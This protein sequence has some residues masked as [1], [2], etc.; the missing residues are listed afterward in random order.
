MR[1]QWRPL[2]P[3]ILTL[4][5]LLC[6][7][8]PLPRT[9]VS[10]RGGLP[11]GAPGLDQSP[12]PSSS[13]GVPRSKLVGTRP[14]L[15]FEPNRGQFDPQVRFASRG[16]GY[17]LFLTDEEAVLSVRGP[18]GSID[19]ATNTVIRLTLDGAN[20]RPPT[21]RDLLPGFVNYLIGN[22]PS[23]WRTEIPTYSRVQYDGVYDGVDLVYYG[24]EGVLEYDLVVEPGTDP[25]QIAMHIGGA[26]RIDLD[27]TGNLL[28]ATKAGTLTMRA[29]VVYQDLDGRREIVEARYAWDGSRTTRFELGAYEPSEPLVID[30]Q[31][32]YSTFL[33]G[34]GDGF[35][36]ASGVAVDAAGSPYIVGTTAT[37]NFP[38]HNPLQPSSAAGGAVVTKLTPDGSQIIYSTYIAGSGSD[39]GIDIAVL[40]NGVAFVLGSTTSTDLPVPN[41]FQAQFGGTSDAFIVQLNAAG[42]AIERGTYLGGSS[43]DSPGGVKFGSGVLEGRLFVHGTTS[44]SNFPTL[45]PGQPTFGG[46]RDAFVT[47]FNPQTLQPVFSSYAGDARDEQA[48]ELIL[49]PIQGDLYIPLVI[50]TS[51]S[52]SA[53]EA[54]RAG[55]I[56]RAVFFNDPE[57]IKLQ[58]DSI[59]PDKWNPI[60]HHDIAWYNNTFGDPVWGPT[61]GGLSSGQGSQA[62][63]S[64]R[65]R[66]G[67][68]LAIA[69]A[70]TPD[71]LQTAV[72]AMAVTGCLP[73][74]PQTTC[75]ER[76]ALFLWDQ[77][78]NIIGHMN[79]GGERR[80]RSFTFSRMTVDLE[81]RFHFIGA[82]SDNALPVVNPIQATY[83][84]SSEGFILTLDPVTGETIFYSY[85]GGSSFEVLADI[86]VDGGGNAWVVGSTQSANFPSTPNAV[87]PALNGRTDA[88]ATKINITPPT[89]ID[90]D[91]LPTSWETRFGL[92]PNSA[93]PANGA[94]GDPDGDG[95]TNAQ[96]LANGTHP[97]G[98]FT[99]YLAEGA[100]GDF[101]D[102]SVALVNPN[103]IS[104]L[105]LLRFLRT[106]GSPVSHY[107]PI[108]SN[109]RA[110]INP[111]SLA[112][113][114]ATAFSTVVESDQ[115]I[116]VDRTMT[117]DAG[118]YGS[119]A[120]TSL[121]APS[122]TW[123]LAEGATHSGFN[124]FY[125]IQ[126]PG[127][128]LAQVQVTYL[129]P[130]P[131]APVVKTYQVAGNARFTI[132]VNQE[133]DG[134]SSTDVSAVI[135][136]TNGIPVIVERA[137]YRDA[138]GQLYGAG[139][140]S[141]GLSALSTN[142][143]L[144]EGATGDFFDLFI[145]IANPGSTDAAI[146][147]TYLLPTGQK[148]TK[149]YGVAA[150][151]R[152]N[153]WVDLEGSE[154]ANT[155][156]ST[157]LTSNV[158]VIVERSMWW[159]FGSATW[160]EAHNSPGAT[161][162]GTRWALAEGEVGGA[163]TTQTYILLANTSAFPGS[164]TVTL[165]FEDGTTT[166]KTFPLAASSRVNVD[167]GFE[168]P[169]ATARRFGAVVESIGAAP[170]QIVVERAMY[171]DAG[172]VV[173]AAGSNAL[174]TR[175]Q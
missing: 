77:D 172:G 170:A 74:P 141:A 80:G 120:E 104:A 83:G 103:P 154:L 31:L 96:E 39:G 69:R 149:S 151:S 168:F 26:E 169:A 48:A 78:F 106:T 79:F 144:A 49:N 136:S 175:L 134:L 55:P 115:P 160:F 65:P 148:V 84:G 51:S 21:G 138:N 60:N 53:S 34:S 63:P 32:L 86:A 89:D 121:A 68:Q 132:W 133:D 58:A 81:G 131:A 46:V 124:L 114:E 13:D 36:Q 123:Y 166:A 119:H 29:P 33:G 85:L 105:T 159:P 24:R 111:E 22:D 128:T 147:A 42:T 127:G 19:P 3:A 117:W 1:H 99:R 9:V 8:G 88:F 16:S 146:T 37:A 118:G 130:S 135:T 109:T 76:A 94:S 28:L 45:N 54:E 52:A 90:N 100:T 102:L 142:W 116:V 153:I 126:N 27:E 107:L 158:P 17:T 67:R 139:H 12:S 163:H 62:L 4:T 161:A 2:L 155:A 125:L 173:W 50:T 10:D 18:A 59:D 113:L 7:G 171:S 40:P 25:S 143:F 14:A 73:V 61:L 152:F 167:V 35:E 56:E 164:A 129:L 162:T 137:M 41:A 101:F 157:T 174:A 165:L 91:G 95:V 30:P 23:R 11:A 57:Y 47:V 5:T 75:S 70:F 92:D 66:D 145:L 82:T 93:D 150:N 140:E 20:P 38:T 108:N 43:G 64:P 15:A 97:R 98:F 122:T 87:Q 72:F 6:L 71:Q 44:S 110:T 156:V 112:G